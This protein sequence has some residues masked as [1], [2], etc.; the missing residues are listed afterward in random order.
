M[1]EDPSKGDWQGALP[2]SRP[3]G[4]RES[5]P[6]PASVVSSASSLLAA[7]VHTHSVKVTRMPAAT[8]SGNLALLRSR[9]DGT[10]YRLWLKTVHSKRPR[11]TPSAQPTSLPSPTTHTRAVTRTSGPWEDR[12]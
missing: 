10:V 6:L 12:V 1:D 5:L 9:R 2:R 3:V 4:N 11:A 8:C 7:C